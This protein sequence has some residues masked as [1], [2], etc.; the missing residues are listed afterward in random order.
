LKQN[1]TTCL[2]FWHRIRVQALKAKRLKQYL[3]FFSKR[4]GGRGLGLFISIR[5][6]RMHGG[7]INIETGGKGTKFTI[8]VPGLK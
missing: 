5:N 7:G 8:T 4:K 3:N 2:Q 6:I 1:T